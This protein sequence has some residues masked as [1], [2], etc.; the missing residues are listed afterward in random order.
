MMP[1][2]TPKHA[3][4]GKTFHSENEFKESYECLMLCQLD[5][6]CKSFNFSQ[7]LQICELNTGTKK[8]FPKKFISNTDY[9]YYEMKYGIVRN[10]L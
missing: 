6:R 9:D 10:E 7:K 5:R 8:Q 2:S 3:L 4:S 1:S